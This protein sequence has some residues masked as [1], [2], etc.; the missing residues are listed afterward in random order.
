MSKNKTISNSNSSNSKAIFSFIV[1][2]VFFLFFV[3]AIIP[4]AFAQ[5]NIDIKIYGQTEDTQ[6]GSQGTNIDIITSNN[7][8][9]N[10]Y[11]S[12]FVFNLGATNPNP[13]VCICG[14]M[15]DKIYITNT[16][17]Y[18]ATFN[19]MTNL[20]D[21]VKLPYSQVKLQSGAT[22]EIN[23][24]VTADCSSKEEKLDYNILVT[25]NFGMQYTIERELQIDRCQ[26]I[27]ATLYASNS[28]VAPCTPVLYTV[29]LKNNVP[30]PEQYI[31]SPKNTLFFDRNKYDAQLAPNR[32]GYFNFTYTPDCNIYGKKEIEFNIQSINNKLSARLN[33]EL[34]IERAYDFSVINDENVSLCR[35]K[36]DVIPV[37][38]KNLAGF[39]NK[40][41][42]SPVN[43]LDLISAPTQT[44]N[45]RQG[46]EF[47][48]LVTAKP[49]DSTKSNQVFEFEIN[50]E[51]GNINYRGR[52]N[53]ETRECYAVDVR[54][55]SDENPSLCSGTHE[56]YVLVENHGLF[57]ERIY[58]EDNSDYAEVY[59]STIVL[60]PQESRNVSLMLSLP[61][62]NIKDLEF[63][64]TARTDSTSKQWSDSFNVDVQ[65]LRDCTMVQFSTKK[66]VA[67]YGT[68]NVT[69]QITNRGTVE[70]S[71]FINYEGTNLLSLKTD[72]VKLNAGESKDIVLDIN[73]DKSE[74]QKK[75]GFKIYAISSNDNIY[76][77]NMVLKMTDTP[78]IQKLYA[79]VISTICTTV[80]AILIFL[81]IVGLI[82]IIV[83]AINN[84]KVPMVLKFVALGLII[85]IIIAVLLSFGL[86]QSRY[87]KIDRA[88][89]D[90]TNLYWYEDETYA[91]DLNE[92]FFDPD[93]D[94]LVFST[95]DELENINI[96][97]NGP[98]VT[99]IPAQNWSGNARIRFIAEDPEGERI[100]SSG[101]NLN[102]LE[103]PEFS[104]IDWYFR[105]CV[106][107]NALLLI[108]LL[109][110]IFL[111][112]NKKKNLPGSE[113]IIR[114]GIKKEK[115]FLYFV[116]KDGDVSKTPMARRDKP[117][118][119][120]RKEKVGR[121]I[122]KRR[123]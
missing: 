48:F 16:A 44:A 102:V 87:P 2:S 119:T 69:F 114:S 25:N 81:I 117:N 113:K 89:S 47:T 38:V 91:I 94:T 115:G 121:V 75:F 66:L 98:I 23:V 52:I 90:Q 109:S 41:T 39:E 53:L 73:V 111:T 64:V 68:E 22:A 103:V 107:I 88:L 8:I 19:L 93:N 21:Y 13:L 57:E 85:L 12:D 34:T 43:K 79:M 74:P 60:E 99:F 36:E 56:Y 45:I 118:Q 35:G 77:N 32:S 24:L 26:S 9:I 123:R 33:H 30:F 61:E 96:S 20:N 100:I 27:T 40:F 3:L 42:F 106:Y 54:I 49:T 62:E 1:F 51:L 105:N 92:Y 7:V 6:S 11:T 80:S 28:T 14:S 108:I 65:K 110:L 31:I 95:E 58:L 67:R 86:P 15:V 5:E 63:T 76:E 101:I 37:K 116:D 59:P 29:E 10:Q 55:I 50:S 112:G 46:D 122:P 72:E 71:Y 97:I 18:E 83:F 104:W 120:F 78:L 17:P 82:I 70:E 84:I 4:S